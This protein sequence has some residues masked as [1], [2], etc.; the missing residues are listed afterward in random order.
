MTGKAPLARIGDVRERRA[1]PKNSTSTV[2]PDDRLVPW[3]AA[4]GPLAYTPEAPPARDSSFQYG[5]VLPQVFQPGLRRHLYFG[6]YDR[7]EAQDLFAFWENARRGSADR[8]ALH[9]GRLANDSVEAPIAVYRH[10]TRRGENH[11]LIIQHGS[12]QCV[13]VEE[14]PEL[15]AGYVHLHRGIGEAKVFH[16]P[17]RLPGG[18]DLRE[19]SR[20]F[21]APICPSTRSMTEPN[22][23]RLPT[24][25]MVPG[26]PTNSRRSE[27]WTSNTKRRSGRYGAPLT[28][29]SRSGAG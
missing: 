7:E 1:K 11:Y 6:A 22:D 3:L 5:W 9:Y 19:S 24:F 17:A 23:R 26:S 12:Y 29:A 2:T 16:F 14:Q 10:S 13:P 21:L 18:S 28:R 4:E 27:G 25:T 15:E 8:V 20:S